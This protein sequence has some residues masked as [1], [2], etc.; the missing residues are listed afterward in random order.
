MYAKKFTHVLLDT[1]GRSGPR[2]DSQGDLP[3]HADS[4]RRPVTENIDMVGAVLF[5]HDG[6]LQARGL[7]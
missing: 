5:R 4:G 6:S 1:L 7:E 3:D 2:R